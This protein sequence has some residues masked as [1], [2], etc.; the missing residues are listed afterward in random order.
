[1]SSKFTKELENLV[2]DQVI[3]SEI[4]EKISQ[5]YR[6]K[7]T[8]GTN[9][10]FIIFGIFG[11]LLIGSGIILML[12]HNWDH[13]SR[14][15]KTILAFVPLLIGQFFAGFSILKNKSKAWKEAS[16]TF[17]FFVVGASIALVSQIYNIIGDLD[18][19]LLTWIVLCLPLIYLLRSHAVALLI[20][21]LST[22]YATTVGYWNYRNDKIPWAYL[23]LF[24][25]VLPHYWMQLKNNSSS[26]VVSIFNWLLPISLIITLGTFIESNEVLG[27]VMYVGLF[28]LFYTIGRLPVFN[29]TRTL[30][31]GLLVLGSLGVVLLCM[32]FTFRWYWEE[33]TEWQYDSLEFYVICILGVFNSLL[34]GYNIF[35]TSIKS[36]NLFQFSYLIF[37][38]L[39]FLFADRV[40][41]SVTLMNIL[42]FAL[43]ISVIKIGTDTFNFG[44]LNY[45]LLIISVLII[46][47]FFDTD[48]SFVVRGILFV[49]VGTGFFITNY[50]MLKRQK[51]KN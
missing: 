35:K 46:C 12:A 6:D 4:S 10:L 2:K 27:F 9:R 19:F 7:N 37:G 24:F 40:I 49:V 34:I 30:R 28:G 18:S 20:L 23:A 45:G 44:I 15:T 50:M 39:F 26:N 8:S 25:A 47:R 21:I 13:F 33:L 11:G 3:S 48:M 42:V 41:V 38:I 5:Y 43:G 31:N 22:N 14:T 1:M 36:V 29:T 32:T 51:N 17:L 16:G